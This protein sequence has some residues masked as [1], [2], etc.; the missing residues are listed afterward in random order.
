MWGAF[1]TLPFTERNAE[2]VQYATISRNIP[3]E[4]FSVFFLSL[5]VMFCDI[6]KRVCFRQGAKAEV[7]WHGKVLKHH[8]T[9]SS[10]RDSVF[11]GCYIC[12]RVWDHLLPDEQRFISNTTGSQINDKSSSTVASSS[13]TG[14]DSS[15]KFVTRICLD[16][17]D[18][19]GYPGDYLLKVAFERIVTL[20]AKS[21]GYWRVT[22]ILQPLDG[23]PR[24]RIV[25]LATV[26]NQITQHCAM[27]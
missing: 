16:E 25:G 7:F 20:P 17:G 22:L 10:L 15:P 19:Y 12:Q 4:S 6:C 24:F 21:A 18:R 27:I 3:L 11:L 5:F 13:L 9:Y 23:K 1:T 8:H 2:S 26:N 14:A